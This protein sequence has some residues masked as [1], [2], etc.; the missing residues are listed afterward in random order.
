MTKELSELEHV[1]LVK[2]KAGDLC[3]A[4]TEASDAGVS[5]ALL[6]PELMVVFRDFGMLP[7]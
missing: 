5:Q 4:L 6:L 7:S 2:E 1:E 3:R